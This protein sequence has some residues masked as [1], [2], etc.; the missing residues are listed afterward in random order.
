[1][2]NK[3]IIGSFVSFFAFQSFGLM[4]RLNKWEAHA[5]IS[6]TT[7]L[8]DPTDNRLEYDLLGSIV[9][10][11]PNQPTKER[12]KFT[13]IPDWLT[14]HKHQ[15]PYLGQPEPDLETL[16][17]VLFIHRHGDRTP[18]QFPV[19]DPLRNDPI[20]DFYGGG[21]IT[22]R[23]KARLHLLGQMIRDRYDK[24]LNGSVN[25]NI[26]ISRSSGSLRCLE[27]AQVF[28]ASFMGLGDP[29]R[30][31]DANKLIWNSSQPLARLWQPVNIQSMPAKMDALL[32]ESAVCDK[33][34]SEYT[35]N[36]NRGPEAR[37]LFKDYA[38][39]AEL[40]RRLLGY[41]MEHFREFFWA[42][43]QIEVEK[44]NFPDRV[45]PEL[46]AA[47]PR[48]E[49]AGH[50]AMSLYQSTL[51]TRRLRCGL[52]INHM[53][54]QMKDMKANGD[55]PLEPLK[56]DLKPFVHY[57]AHDLNLVVLLGIWDNWQRFQRRPDYASNML[58]ELH[59]DKKEN[60]WFVKILYMPRVPHELIELH[61]PACES[62]H[63][64]SRC[65]LEKFEEIM[66]IYSVVSWQKW[67]GEC[68]NSYDSLDP[69]EPG[70]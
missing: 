18:I 34:E 52:L 50:K 65:T 57:S 61:I 58:L 48:I 32:A 64:K 17:Q 7:K 46:V 55:K 6:S 10:S 20:W 13:T 53:I 42:S 31:F 26:R 29:E 30:H 28:L 49:E 25:K 24:F 56:S 60:E 59:R 68:N 14:D 66:Q 67:M 33:L 36:I 45:N 63:P 16:K 38:E 43:S 35:D 40:L 19:Q 1:M 47:F 3:I 5:A 23:G 54:K 27:S 39:E 8:S 62:G 37:Q 41:K 44:S 11:K 51:I 2:M 70:Q 15:S 22:N 21:Q 4:S 12:V 69:Y 9:N